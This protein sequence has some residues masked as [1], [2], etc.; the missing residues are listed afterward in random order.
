M[1]NKSRKKSTTTKK[2]VSNKKK[3]AKK[4]NKSRKWLILA[5]LLAV[6][7]AV[8][9]G[10][11]LVNGADDDVIIK[12][13]R[14]AKIENV[15]DSIA[16][17]L[18][19]EYA[20]MVV[21]VMKTQ[22]VDLSERNGAY[23]IP[24]GMNPAKAA[25]VLT[26]GG[27]AG[28]KVVL[29]HFRTKKDLAKFFSA[30]LD[31]TEKEFL[32]AFNDSDI[33]AT[34]DLKP[35]QMIALFMEDTYEFYWSI[36]PEQ[37]IEKMA[38]YYN[39]YWNDSRVEDAKEM[40][41]TPIEVMT[42]CSIVDEETA[43][44]DEKGKIGRLYLNRL[45]K[46]MRLQADPT[47]KFASGNFGLRRITSKQTSLNSPYNTYRVKG[48]PPGPIGTTSK[49]TLNEFLDSREHDYL[50]MCAKEDFSGYH[51]FSVTYE[52]HQANARRYQKALN[53]RGI[54]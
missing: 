2:R 46:G 54:K 1:E 7:G 47:A 9:L 44:V 24:K 18:G 36:T 53:E 51:N 11:V 48:L 39:R 42:L 4:P 8:A 15:E 50:F 10:Y 5:A 28:V 22:K 37:L 21:S 31:M 49:Q 23:K 43:K 25:R 35:E 20:A 29:R 32:S 41:L 33:Q 30:R 45:N 3:Q 12:I 16:K 40:G 52:E 26:H 17:Y 6:V 14:G 19:D 27:E 13:P 38:M 34:Y